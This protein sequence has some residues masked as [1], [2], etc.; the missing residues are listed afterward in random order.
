MLLKSL[1]VFILLTL[2][3]MIGIWVRGQHEMIQWYNKQQA[4]EAVRSVLPKPK[5]TDVERMINVSTPHADAIVAHTFSITGKARGGWYSE[6]VFPLEI[7]NDSGVTL[8]TIPIHA[9]GD[10]PARGAQ[11]GGQAG[12]TT[13][14]FVPFKAKISTPYYSGKAKLIFKKAN[15]SGLSENDMSFTVPITIQ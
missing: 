7:Q 4:L 1:M 15:P 13:P 10:L 9:E 6:G 3:F 12:W 2:A 8:E 14:D 11:A 5:V